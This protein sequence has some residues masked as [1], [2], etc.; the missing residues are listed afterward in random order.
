VDSAECL[1]TRG[2]LLEILWIEGSAVE[3]AKA[4]LHLKIASAVE[5]QICGDVCNSFLNMTNYSVVQASSVCS[6]I[7]QQKSS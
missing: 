7:T 5:D 3:E 6:R 2:M 1:T 4:K